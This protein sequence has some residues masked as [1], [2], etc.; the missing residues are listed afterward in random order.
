MLSGLVIRP[1]GT[2]R[3]KEKQLAVKQRIV[4]IEFQ[5]FLQTVIH[6]PAQIIR[7]SSRL[8]Y[9]LLSYRESV[10]TLL[11]IHDNASRPLR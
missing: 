1:T 4:R 6:I 5:T 8:I 3:Q 2:A 10:E 11:L 9:R 7:T